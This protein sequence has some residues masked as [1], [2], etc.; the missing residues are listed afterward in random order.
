MFSR[1]ALL[2]SARSAAPQRALIGQVRTF[3][4]PASE[5]V[6]PPVALFGLDGT[7]ATALVRPPLPSDRPIG[8]VS[9]T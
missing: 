8:F 6:T 1:Q 7:Y 4:A 3:A 5:K 2:R 9:S